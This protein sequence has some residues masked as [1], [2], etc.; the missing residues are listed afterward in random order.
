[1]SKTEN[2]KPTI[3]QKIGQLNQA[4]EWFYGDDFSL[5]NATEKYQ[6]AITLAT[7]I[8]KDLKDLKNKITVLDQDFTKA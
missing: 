6:A 3:T 5:E 8:E 1:M 7:E 4:V 2:T